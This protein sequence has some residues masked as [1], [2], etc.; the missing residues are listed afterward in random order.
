MRTIVLHTLEKVIVDGVIRNSKI[1]DMTV[2]MV[3]IAQNA[4]A[5]EVNKFNVNSSMRQLA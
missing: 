1:M 2:I 5:K 3:F 4:D